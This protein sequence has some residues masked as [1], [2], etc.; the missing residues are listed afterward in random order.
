MD[1]P[2]PLAPLDE[3]HAGVAAEQALH[4]ARARI[5]K[6]GE[7][8]E[9]A[10]AAGIGA[11]LLGD[12]QQ[13]RIARH[14]HAERKRRR[15]GELGEEQAGEVRLLALLAHQPARDDRQDQLAQQRPDL[16]R[17]AAPTDLRAA[18]GRHVDGAH[19]QCAARLD[20]M[21]G[22]R[23]RPE[24][25]AGRDQPEGRVRSDPHRPSRGEDELPPGMLVLVQDVA[26]GEGQA[27]AAQGVAHRAFVAFSK[28]IVIVAIFR[29]KSAP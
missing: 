10:V 12:P 2:Q 16:D 19:R 26:V 18:L 15:A 25:A 28:E 7:A 6:A 5:G 23:R 9:I 20:L 14:R 22:A 24:R 8:L 29:R 4:G 13:P 21:A 3:A 17:A 11:E 27:D 1:Q